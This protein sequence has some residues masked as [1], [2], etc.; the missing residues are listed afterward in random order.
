MILLV[1]FSTAARSGEVLKSYPF[2][3]VLPAWEQD[4]TDFDMAIIEETLRNWFNKNISNSVIQTF[5]ILPAKLEDMSRTEDGRRIFSGKI[6]IIWENDAIKDGIAV[7]SRN[8]QVLRLRNSGSFEPS[9]KDFAPSLKL[10]TSIYPHRRSATDFKRAVVSVMEVQTKDGKILIPLSAATSDMMAKFSLSLGLNITARIPLADGSLFATHRHVVPDHFLVE[11][12]AIVF[13][14]WRVY[15]SGDLNESLLANAVKSLRAK[16]WWNSELGDQLA[17]AAY[18]SDRKSRIEALGE[19]D[20]N[21]FK[22]PGPKT[23]SLAKDSP[24]GTDDAA[25]EPKETKEEPSGSVVDAGYQIMKRNIGTGKHSVVDLVEETATKQLYAWKQPV[26]DAESHLLSFEEEIAR[27]AIWR[28]LGVSKVEVKWAEDHKSLFKTFVKGPTLR[29]ALNTN[30]S[31]LTDPTHPMHV[32]LRVF[33]KNLFDSNQY[34]GDVNNKNLIFDG[35][36][37]QIIDSGGIS[38]KKSKDDAKAEYVEK[39]PLKWVKQVSYEARDKLGRFFDFY[40]PQKPEEKSKRKH[41]KD[42]PYERKGWWKSCS[43][44]FFDL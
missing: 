18:L 28:E 22:K 21:S 36:S 3:I 1:G 12:E 2:K 6:Q 10:A 41:K 30:S 27:S 33:L 5:K 29:E 17:K 8:I 9:S 43:E 13:D 44:A 15:L 11:P 35:E 14:G 40:K 32:A 7:E 16:T 20:V 4:L 42:K 38:E 24:V 23:P 31:F 34:I 26:T 37:W 19:I 39:L 25:K